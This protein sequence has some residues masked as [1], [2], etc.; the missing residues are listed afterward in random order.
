MIDLPCSE[1]GHPDCFMLFHFFQ[2][3][4][5]TVINS[6]QP[7]TAT[8]TPTFFTCKMPPYYFGMKIK[9]PKLTGFNVNALF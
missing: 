3:A 9:N 5:E 7:F 1:A 6:A 4:A 2:K 8:V